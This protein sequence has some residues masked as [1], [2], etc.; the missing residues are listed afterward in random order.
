MNKTY[1]WSVVCAFLV[2]VHSSVNAEP[3]VYAYT[4]NNF[5]TVLNPLL[6]TV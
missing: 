1:L 2:F 6:L 4:G 5:D 3:Y